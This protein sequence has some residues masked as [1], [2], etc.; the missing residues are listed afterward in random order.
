LL[1]SSDFFSFIKASYLYYTAIAFLFITLVIVMMIFINLYQKDRRAK[2]RARV[3]KTLENW[4]FTVL[5]GEADEDYTTLITPTFLKYIS[6]PRHRQY[7][8]DQLINSKKNLTGTACDNIIKLYEALG[9]QKESLA[10]MNSSAWH[11]KAKGIYELYMMNQVAMK[12]RILHY[13]NSGNEFVRMEAQTA[14]IG[15]MGF[16]GL[17]FLETL[18][19]PLPNWQQVKLLEQLRPLDL[20]EMPNLELW[21]RSENEYVVLFALKL[22][23][24]Y[25]QMHIH[26]QVTLCLL[27]NNEQI[28]KQAIKALIRTP[29]DDTVRTIIYHYH[30][31][32]IANKKDIL[33]GLADIGSEDETDFLLKEM[34]HHDDDVKL[35]AAKAL[36][37]CAL[38]GLDLLSSKA[39]ACPEPYMPIFLHVKARLAS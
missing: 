19:K 33:R 27:S 3:E 31:E 30:N 36:A 18:N 38:N 39:E 35:E 28:R 4:L 24:I 13:T 7:V 26:E 37:R 12:D 34:H 22:S 10:K 1:L 16:E 8:I 25:Q 11:I 20:T 23:E 5:L 21:L 29:H 9:L 15:F 6:H 14:I 32:T 2:T 17:V